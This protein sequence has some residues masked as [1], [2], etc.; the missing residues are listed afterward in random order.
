MSNE[1]KLHE[2]ASHGHRAAHA[3]EVVGEALSD[4][5]GEYIKAW[6]STPARD[7]D[8]RER[9]WQAVQIVGKV[10]AHIKRMVDDGKIAERELNEIARFGERR[11]IFGVV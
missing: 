10:E 7:T 11:K 6:R 4:L 9:L 3:L 8:A 5:E 2:A 1:T